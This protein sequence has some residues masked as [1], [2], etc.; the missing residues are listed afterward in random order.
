M[1]VT[2]PLE[3]L[4]FYS[5]HNPPT[6]EDDFA[7]GSVF[8]LDKPKGVSSSKYIYRLKRLLN[9]VKLGHTGTL[10]PM[11][12]GLLLVCTGKATKSVKF[13][14]ELNKKYIGE[15]TL[16]AATPSCDAETDVEEMAD[17]EHITL[18]LINQKL[19]QE[20]SGT[21]VQYPPVYSAIRKNGERLYKKARRG[22]KVQVPPRQVSIYNARAYNKD[23]PI[24]NLDITCSRGTYIRS[25]ARDIGKA[26]GSLAY[27][28]DLQRTAIGPHHVDN[29]FSISEL[30]S[31]LG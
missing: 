13:I 19:E 29:A 20:F 30:E 24:F 23:G 11:A 27:L 3:K 7:A 10:D 8:L 26:V 2:I 31:I 16:G 15:V 28:S 14:Q 21:I 9:N 6:P 4:I 12:T 18:D 22:E 25:I 5:K 17:W 1:A